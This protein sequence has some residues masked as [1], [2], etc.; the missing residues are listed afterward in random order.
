MHINRCYKINALNQSVFFNHNK[1]TQALTHYLFA[2]IVDI[3]I[4]DLVIRVYLAHRRPE[5]HIAAHFLGMNN[6][7]KGFHIHY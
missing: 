4:M 2:L 5:K 6:Y 1:T 3:I 7:T